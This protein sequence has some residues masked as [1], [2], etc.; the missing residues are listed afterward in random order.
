MNHVK[1]NVSRGTDFNDSLPLSRTKIVQDLIW[2]KIQRPRGMAGRVLCRTLVWSF[3]LLCIISII[4]ERGTKLIQVI[5]S[6][7]ILSQNSDSCGQKKGIPTKEFEKRPSLG[8]DLQKDRILENIWTESEEEEPD[9]TL[10]YREGRIPKWTIGLGD[11][12]DRSLLKTSFWRWTGKKIVKEFTL[13]HLL[14]GVKADPEE[15]EGGA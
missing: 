1:F 3:S 5:S 13:T 6:V 14:S 15:T 10:M 4:T 7:G 12:K 11:R 9:T 2:G 8:K